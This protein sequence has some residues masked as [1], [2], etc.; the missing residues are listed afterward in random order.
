[1]RIGYI[2]PQTT[3]EAVFNYAEEFGRPIRPDHH[4]TIL[5][6]E[7]NIS[8]RCPEI[9]RDIS[10]KY[11]S[12]VGAQQLD[13]CLGNLS[14]PNRRTY[15]RAPD[16]SPVSYRSFNVLSLT[17]FCKISRN[18]HR[19]VKAFAWCLTPAGLEPTLSPWKGGVLTSLRS[20]IGDS[21]R[22]RTCNLYL[23]AAAEPMLPSLS[24][25]SLVYER[26]PLCLKENAEKIQ[27]QSYYILEFMMRFI[28]FSYCPSWTLV[29]WDC[30]SFG[31][32]SIILR[33]VFRY[34]LKCQ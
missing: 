11:T 4:A 30:G 18:Q 20:H 16:I 17:Y 32:K 27:A 15:T 33:G 1:M 29:S 34:T 25:Y 26:I 22:S 19:H 6:A 23:M 24:G 2:L 12:P 21:G 9:I 10:D 8:L 7:Y 31:K 5:F 28:I 13:T 14:L 3:Q